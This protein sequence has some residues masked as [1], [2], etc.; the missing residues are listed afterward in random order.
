MR[1]PVALM[2]S[3]ND[4]PIGRL[5]LCDGCGWFGTYKG[6]GLVPNSPSASF[7]PEVWAL[8]ICKPVRRPGKI[9]MISLDGLATYLEGACINNIIP[10]EPYYRN[11]DKLQ[12]HCFF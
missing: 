4:F 11:Q 2:A 8:E 1:D 5:G 12:G 3:V 10:V 7:H 6:K 9:L